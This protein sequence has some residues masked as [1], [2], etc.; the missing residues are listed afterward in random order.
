MQIP[1]G[2][3]ESKLRKMLFNEITFIIAIIGATVGFISYFNSPAIQNKDEIMILSARLDKEVALT[4]QL[5]SI[6]D[7]DLH[8]I[9]VKLDQ[10]TELI[11]GLQKEVVKL[12]TIIE[13]R[14]P[15]KK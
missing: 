4:N 3:G 7:N 2:N 15:I 13:E 12:Q 8:T 11:I 6:K 10:N 1:I 9:T 14:L 5:N